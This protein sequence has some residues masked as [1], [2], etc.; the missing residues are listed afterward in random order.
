ML[1][2]KKD[3]PLFDYDPDIVFLDSGASTQ[4]PQYVIDGVDEYIKTS[5]A[6]IH[7]W[8]YELSEK[9]EEYYH[10]SKEKCGEVLGC[11]A[12][13]IIYT[14]NATYGINLISQSLFRSKILQKGDAVL[15]GIWE[16]HANV[17][18]RQVLEEMFGIE[19]RFV[20]I[21]KNY[22]I[23]RDDFDAK[24]DDKVKIVSFGQVSNVTGKIY[25]IKEIKSK[26]REDTFFMVDGSQGI[27]HFATQVK[28]VDCDCYIFTGHKMMAYSWIWVVY[29]DKK[30]IKELTPMIGWGWTIAD[31]ST[32]GCT[33]TTWPDKFEAG[34]PNMIGAVSVLKAFE[35]MEK[36]G[37]YEE[38][39]K[40]EQELIKLT[41]ARFEKLKDKVTLVGPWKA[42]ERA[43]CF[44][45]SIPS[46]PNFNLIWEKF[47]EKNICV[48][49]GAHCAYPLHRFLEQK[50]TCRMSLLFF[51]DKRD[52]ERFFEVLEEIVEG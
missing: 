43:W 33:F 41:L 24:Y 29:L 17:V 14:Y 3:F 2:I 7:R 8:S 26:L 23:D 5:Y 39:L 48:R 35:Y 44:S 31:V 15:V 50:G 1:D 30:W 12:S 28:E 34:T 18:P 49:C 9:S 42:E 22:D 40:H 51:N 38:I 4:R 6:N 10:A 20:N 37:W 11:K 32:S 47:A 46:M 13:E 52:I 19:V 45:F 27:Q 25:D 16:H 21:D 36:I